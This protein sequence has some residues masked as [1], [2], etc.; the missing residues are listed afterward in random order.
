[1][2]IKQQFKKEFTFEE[3]GIDYMLVGVLILIITLTI[4]VIRI[5]QP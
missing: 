1:M 4:L 5:R 3:Y 2:D